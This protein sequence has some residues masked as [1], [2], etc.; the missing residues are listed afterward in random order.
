MPVGS[1]G[2]ALRWASLDGL[3]GA[4]DEAAQGDD[5][6]PDKTPAFRIYLTG[7]DAVADHRVRFKKGA[8]PR[9]FVLEWTGRIALTYAGDDEL[10]YTFR[11]VVPGV[12][13][14]GFEVDAALSEAE[15]TRL[16]AAACLG[17]ERF[18][19][20]EID[21]RRVFCEES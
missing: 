13:F 18:K 8:I 6:D 10:K 19:L 12:I 7:H 4:A 16:F 9:A 5:V 1:P 17:A 11:A 20:R 14:G 21:G 15:A 3:E 2:R